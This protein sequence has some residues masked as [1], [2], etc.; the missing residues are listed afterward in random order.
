M[1]VSSIFSLA[2]LASGATAA[3]VTACGGKAQGC[4]DQA[5]VGVT[6][7]KA[8]DWACGC[9]YIGAIQNAATNC[10]IGACGNLNSALA[11][12]QEARAICQKS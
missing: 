11:A 3:S 12:A 1:Q 7:C 6:P 2:F 4:I 10:V 9:K 5:V 8:G